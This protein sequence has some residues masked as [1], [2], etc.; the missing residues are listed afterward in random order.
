MRLK[1]ICKLCAKAYTKCRVNFISVQSAAAGPQRT[2][3]EPNCR[4]HAFNRVMQHPRNILQTTDMP[5]ATCTVL[6]IKLSMV[7]AVLHTHTQFLS[8]CKKDTHH[9]T[10]PCTSTSVYFL[11]RQVSRYS[12]PQMPLNAQRINTL[13][14]SLTDAC[15]D[16]T[17]LNNAVMPS[18]SVCN[19]S[20][21]N[22]APCIH[23]PID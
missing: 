23:T 2:D 11:Q 18:T 16:T 1:R 9:R 8:G 22:P 5:A 3:A 21:A 17:H 10:T 14:D 12:D 4:T 6:L 7:N 19:A 15:K 13:K 20:R